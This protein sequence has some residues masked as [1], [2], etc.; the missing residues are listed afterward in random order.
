[1]DG[2]G[3]GEL[4]DAA[5]YGDEGSSTLTNI[6]TATGGLHLPNLGRFGLGNIVPITGVPPQSKPAAAYGKLIE[7]SKGKDSTTGHWELAGVIT[8]KP[9]AVYPDGFPE[10]IV[11]G[12]IE[13][14][15]CGGVLGNIPASGTEIIERLGTAHIKTGYPILYTSADPVFQ[16]A[17][18]EQIVPPERLYRWCEIARNE[19]MI[20]E[21][22]VSRVIARPFIGEPGNFKRT[23]NRK[24]FSLAPPVLTIIDYLANAGIPTVTIG[25][26][27]NLFAGRGIAR[28]IHTKGNVEGI[29]NI[30]RELG[31]LESGLVFTNLI[32]FDQEYG[33]RNDIAGFAAALEEFDRSIPD[34]TSLV[35]RDDILIITSDHGND[36]TTPSTDHSREYAP[37]LAYR[38]GRDGGENLGTRE[39]FADIARTCADHF[40]LGPDVKGKLAGESFYPSLS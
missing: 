28:V 22:T 4:P 6:S 24:D 1:M 32:D 11:S 15:G 2:V 23:V 25:K 37:L 40:D 3:A 38:S 20:G 14:T 39:T 19:L 35:R 10:E 29:E 34:I 21:H 36:P 33:H 12:F 17:A 27:D 7:R 8:E 5:K 9:F 30:I 16:L 18:H 13:L 26:V 31:S